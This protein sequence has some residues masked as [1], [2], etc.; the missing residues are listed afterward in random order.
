MNKAEREV[1]L[2][3]VDHLKVVMDAYPSNPCD[4]EGL[5]KLR[6]IA[7]SNVENAMSA[8]DYLRRG[9]LEQAKFWVVD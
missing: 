7:H 9:D 8:L 6:N 3:I 5:A 1:L 4:I 2:L